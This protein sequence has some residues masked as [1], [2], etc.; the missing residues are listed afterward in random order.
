L[1]LDRK[2][3]REV[4]GAAGSRGWAG[5]QSEEV[6]GGWSRGSGRSGGGAWRQVGSPG[7][8][9]PRPFPRCITRPRIPLS[10]LPPSAFHLHRFPLNSGPLASC[11]GSC[12]VLTG[13]SR[14]LG[15]PSRRPTP[16]PDRS[17]Q[18]ADDSDTGLKSAI[19]HEPLQGQLTQALEI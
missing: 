3:M 10:S 11:L 5:P 15:P 6:E 19:F 17:I 16:C 1:I 9:R 14:A 4:K 7:R 2:G 18:N 13:L 12:I 8:A